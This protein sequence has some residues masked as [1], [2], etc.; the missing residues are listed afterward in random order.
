MDFFKS[1][2][3]S[4]ETHDAEVERLVRDGASLFEQIPAPP[5]MGIRPRRDLGQ[6]VPVRKGDLIIDASNDNRLLIATGE[7]KDDKPVTKEL[8]GATVVLEPEFIL[9]GAFSKNPA[10]K[11]AAGK[12]ATQY[13]DRRILTYGVL[14]SGS[15]G[16][17]K[18]ETTSD[19]STVCNDKHPWETFI[20]VA[21]KK[22]K[23]DKK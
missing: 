17:G 22:N 20:K 18:Q 14:P 9:V 4:I 15:L 5:S 19:K 12:L 6:N 3:A 10:I 23:K 2:I 16:E 13:P 21:N 1:L 11:S 7:M 8:N